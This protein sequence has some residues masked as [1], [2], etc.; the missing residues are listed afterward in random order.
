M[1]KRL[2][3]VVIILQILCYPVWATNYYVRTD[4]SDSNDGSANDSGHAFLTIQ[5][6]ADTAGA[7]DTCYVN[8]G[9]YAGWYVEDGGTSASLKVF[10]CLGTC[11]I[12][13]G[14]SRNSG[15]DG[16]TVESYSGGDADYVTI[17]GFTVTGQTRFGI[18]AINGTGIV[19]QNCY[20]YNNTGDCGIFSGNTPH[21][22]ILNN[23]CIG[24]GSTNTEHNIYVSNAESDY[25]TIRG[26]IC[27]NAGGGNGI[28]INGDYQE[29]GDGYIDYAVIEENIIYGNDDKGVSFISGRDGTIQNNVIYNNGPSA[30]GIHI[31]SQLGDG[32]C[33]STGN[34]ITNNTIIAPDAVC[35]RLADDG[36]TDNMV[37]NNICVYNGDGILDEDGGNTEVTNLEITSV[38]SNFENAGAHDYHLASGSSAINYGTASSGGFDAPT[39]DFDGTTRSSVDAGAFEYVDGDDFFYVRAHG[40]SGSTCTLAAPCATIAAGITA[41]SGGDTLTVHDGYYDENIAS[42]D[43]PAGSSGDFTVVQAQNTNGPTIITP[44][45]DACVQIANNYI[46]FD[47]FRVDGDATAS[48]VF[49][50]GGDYV[51]VL[52]CAGFNAADTN[53]GNVFVAYEGAS[54][55]LFEECWAWGLGARYKFQVFH[56]NNVIVRRCVARLDYRGTGTLQ[57]ANFNNY[58]SKD[59]MFQNCIAIDS[60]TADGVVC[61]GDGITDNIFGAFFLENKE[62][63]QNDTTINLEG[64]IVLN[65]T[66]KTTYAAGVFDHASGVHTINNLIM[67]DNVAGYAGDQDD[68]PNDTAYIYI[69]YM[70]AGLASGSYD[71][72]NGRQANGVGA[73]IHDS[74]TNTVY[75]SIFWDNAS[76]GV[77]DYANSNYNIFH[78]NGIAAAGGVRYSASVGAGSVTDHDP[79]SYGLLYLPRVEPD[80]YLKTAC[81]GGRCGA[82]VLYKHGTDGTLYGEPGYN[83]LTSDELW[84]YPNEHLIKA[85]FASYN[86]PGP[87]GARGFAT[88]TSMDGNPQTLTKYVWEYL[89][90]QIPTDIYGTEES[91]PT[92]TQSVGA[93]MSGCRIGW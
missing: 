47:G 66:T 80:S 34:L 19:I 63:Y 51:K 42:T 64:N 69:D 67:Y 14:H 93:G 3:I 86:G 26:N 62:D 68:P 49:R 45:S 90:N 38:G 75:H 48:S 59:T 78:G 21:I 24:N 25:P 82:E 43:I 17:D 53:N 46:T 92:T 8:D 50:V 52:R 41:M 13:S 73:Q 30:G 76:Y 27:G 37:M 44:D 74:L 20:V 22:Y 83:T 57:C 36:S 16:I 58:D 32:T 54:Y 7:G 35:I 2:L 39:D 12:T 84:P 11:N 31:V 77:A 65:V 23:V 85:D 15:Y 88:G 40:G 56:A 81:N 4:G 79:E 1:V 10:K 87:A 9:T 60:D 18:R 61:A 5:H 89:G 71:A 28:Q 70:T 91:D 33:P 29:G 72:N 6:C 55:V